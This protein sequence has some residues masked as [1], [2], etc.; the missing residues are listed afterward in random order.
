[1]NNGALHRLSYFDGEGDEVTLDLADVSI[2]PDL[3]P[4]LFTLQVPEGTRVLRRTVK[5]E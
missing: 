5:K 2:N 1:M 4:D 3:G